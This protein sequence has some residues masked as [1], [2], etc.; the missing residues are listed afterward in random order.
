[1]PGQV[2]GIKKKNKI[3]DSEPHPYDALND[4]CMTTDCIAIFLSD[5]DNFIM[6]IYD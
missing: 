6:V 1:M 3:R 5:V 2:E 4:G